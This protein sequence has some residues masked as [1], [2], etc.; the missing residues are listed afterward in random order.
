MILVVVLAPSL[1]VR[2]GLGAILAV[3]PQVDVIAQ[4]SAFQ[5]LETLPPF[6]VLVTT[7]EAFARREPGTF[8][9]GLEPAPALLL[10]SD[11]PNAAQA[12]AQLPLRAW[13]LLPEDCSEDE[14]LSAVQ[15]LHQGLMVST[16][17]AIQPLLGRATTTDTEDLTV[18]ELTERETEVLELLAEGMANKQ[19]A[20][21]LGISEH[22][23]KFHVSS[24]YTKLAVSNRTEAVRRG[25]QLGL[26]SL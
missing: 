5:E 2:A 17:A 11:D 18:D 10:L 24:I 6:D 1:A 23:I 26:I 13:G 21:Q 19:I 15:A 9:Q 7:A 8:A 16:P 25:I 20:Y 14:L 22:T 12:L 4:A 3:D